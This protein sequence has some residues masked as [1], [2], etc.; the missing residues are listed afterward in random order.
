MLVKRRP[1]EQLWSKTN[2]WE[3]RKF[4]TECI[5][6]IFLTLFRNAFLNICTMDIGK[7]Q[8]TKKLNLGVEIWFYF[9]LSKIS[10]I[11]CQDSLHP[12]HEV[13]NVGVNPRCD[14]SAAEAP[15]HNSNLNELPGHSLQEERAWSRFSSLGVKCKD[16]PPESPWQESFPRAPAQNIFLNKIRIKN[17]NVWIPS[18]NDEIF[19]LWKPLWWGQL[20][21]W[22]SACMTLPTWLLHWPKNWHTFDSHALGFDKINMYD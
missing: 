20:R 2:H 19:P 13:A 3:R 7:D 16:L 15:R 4:W 1:K 18:G 11:V 21:F 5:F 14:V 9:S 10:S 22:S 8:P 6:G 12:W 17:G